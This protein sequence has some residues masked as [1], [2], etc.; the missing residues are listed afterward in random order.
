MKYKNQT[1]RRL[2]KELKQDTYV[3]MEA[4]KAEIKRYPWTYWDTLIQ[5]MKKNGE[6]MEFLR[7]L[8]ELEFTGKLK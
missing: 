2:L 4:A 5:T 3:S 1:T 8:I 6:K 7:D